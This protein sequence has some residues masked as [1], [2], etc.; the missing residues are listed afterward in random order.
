M[1]VKLLSQGG[2]GCV[3]YPGLFCDGKPLGNEK[4]VTKLQVDAEW[5]DREIFI[6]SM[7]VKIN[8]FHLYFAPVIESCDIN[9]KKITD[10]NILDNCEIIKSGVQDYKIMFIPYIEKQGFLYT[11]FKDYNSKVLL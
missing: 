10:P 2:Y 5:T 7:I 4:L 8:N 9:I 3:Y 11:L 6:G 1:S